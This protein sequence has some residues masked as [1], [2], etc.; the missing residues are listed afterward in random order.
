LGA[1]AVGE[2]CSGGDGKL[3]LDGWVARRNSVGVDSCVCV[4]AAAGRSLA[5]MSLI[6]P[7]IKFWSWRGA[8]HVAQSFGMFCVPGYALYKLN[9]SEIVR[10]DLEQ[11]LP[12]RPD[13]PMGGNASNRVYSPGEQKLQ[14]MLKKVERVR[15]LA[16]RVLRLP[17]PRCALVRCQC[18]TGAVAVAG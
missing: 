3:L 17:C 10:G 13:L 8:L 12:K 15:G 2:A 7:G 5:I 14:D 6:A 16:P 4:W 1:A 9:T 18:I 11:K